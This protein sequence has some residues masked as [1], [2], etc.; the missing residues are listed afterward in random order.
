MYVCIF[1]LIRCPLYAK[2]YLR[3]NV[4]QL[5]SDII[6]KETEWGSVYT[7]EFASF[8]YL[9]TFVVSF[10]SLWI[11]IVFRRVVRTERLLRLPIGL[12]TLIFALITLV[13]TSIVTDGVIKFCTGSETNICSSSGTTIFSSSRWKII[14]L[15]IGKNYRF[16]F[17]Y[18]KKN[19][20][21]EIFLL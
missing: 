16:F 10:I 1:Y 18:Q 2:L 8:A 19:F 13:A 17:F 12:L 15:P 6:E 14:S 3:D 11:H 7:C 21:C 20:L 9:S 4:T 5:S